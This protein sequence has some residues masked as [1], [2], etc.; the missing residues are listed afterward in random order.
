MFPPHNALSTTH[1]PP[2]FSPA[3][4]SKTSAPVSRATISEQGSASSD[5][6]K[7]WGTEFWWDQTRGPEYWLAR[8]LLNP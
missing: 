5:L 6:S 2:F 8:H 3:L 1:T 7:V 4:N